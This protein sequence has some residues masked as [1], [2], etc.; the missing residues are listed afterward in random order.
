MNK[1]RILATIIILTAINF[2]AEITLAKNNN[3]VEVSN[4]TQHSSVYYNN[5]LAE[6]KANNYSSA[7]TEFKKALRENSQ[8]KSSRIQL[9]N[10]YL[11]RAQYYNNKAM[12]YNKAANDLRS[13]IFYIKYYD[14]E[15]TDAQ[16]VNDINTMENNLDT[17]LKA[18]DADLTLKGRYTMGKSL[19][20]QGEFPAA[21]TEFQK[22]QNDL[23]YKK[24]S[25]AN[26]GEIYHIL[27][28]N[29]QAVEYLKEAILLDPENYKLHVKL[30]S[31]Y[32]RLGKTNLAADEYNLALSK[33]E[34]NEDVLTSLENIWKQKVNTYP[35]D[36]EAHANL[37][38]IYQK[39]KD[40][41]A[42]IE[43]YKK[44]ESLNPSNV[45]TRLNFGTLYQEQKQYETAIEAYDS[46]LIIEP[47]HTLA[48]YYKA[49][50]YKALGN[51]DSAI[52]H[53]KL[54]LNSDPSNKTIQNELN[55]YYEASMTPEQKLAHLKTQVEN[56]PQD[57][58][59]IYR[60]AYELHKAKRLPEAISSYSQVIKLNPHNE[61]AYINLAQAYKQ[62]SNYE[63][64]KNTLENAKTVFPES[65]MIKK[66]LASLEAETT[67]LLYADA[68]KLYN[69]KKY[70]EAIA[71]YTKITPATAE[72]YLGIGACYQAENKY[73]EAA[74]YYEKSFALDPKNK[75]T[76]YYVALAYANAS[77]F[78]KAKVFAH[79]ALAID[80]NYKDAKDLVAYV[81][82]QECTQKVDQA[83][84][85]IDKNNHQQALTLLNAVIAMDKE[86]ADAYFYRG[87]IYDTQK[88]YPLAI[89]DY[90]KAVEY[91][92]E[93]LIANYSIAIDYDALAQYSNAL[94]YHK[95]Y[96]ALTQ[97][98][99]ETNDYTRYSARRIQ[100]L[101]AYEPKAETKK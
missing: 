67:S 10:T 84:E 62:Q 75:E 32:E 87:M 25:L 89:A 61:D 40:Y 55:E 51:K 101:K 38:A 83:I 1:K 43:Q 53:Y 73:N 15:P 19:R 4:Y 36:A 50:C 21:I 91:N 11:A 7:I 69:E 52:H 88:R 100:E 6:L 35:N 68:S 28:L 54:A 26:L 77:N 46:I 82:E 71:I 78:N 60:Y 33:S 57:A 85:L 23:A 98:I 24:Q 74:S 18:I 80:I 31:T 96:L 12:D 97:K 29:N 13:A 99:G 14:N 76:A 90:K 48:H 30:A 86:N 49:Q 20:A 79:K 8:D 22:A 27:N 39:K 37:G 9:V 70:Q 72:S 56:N 94:T 92:P 95:K 41:T 3:T 81:I 44:A 93:M 59:L 63:L 47:G 66:Q 16:Y 5:G 45:T 17:V 58:N 65:T 34:N 64:A 2:H 42:A